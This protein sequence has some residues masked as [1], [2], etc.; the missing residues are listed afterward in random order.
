MPV[1]GRRRIRG[2][3]ARPGQGKGFVVAGQVYEER[4]GVGF[5][6]IPL[7]EASG[8]LLGQPRVVEQVAR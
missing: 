6:L 2:F 7:L 3:Q 5:V 1:V 8:A 4:G